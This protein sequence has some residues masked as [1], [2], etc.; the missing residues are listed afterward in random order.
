MEFIV[1]L[2]VGSMKAIGEMESN[3]AMENIRLKKVHLK[4]AF[5][6]MEKENFG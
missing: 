4:W 5:G 3:M 6:K 2:M 1:G